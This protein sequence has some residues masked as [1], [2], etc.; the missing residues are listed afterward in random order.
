MNEML[1]KI[2]KPWVGGGHD[3]IVTAP[4]RV[5]GHRISLKVTGG[6]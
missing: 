5:G 3:S 4:V 1:L 2:F 6:Q